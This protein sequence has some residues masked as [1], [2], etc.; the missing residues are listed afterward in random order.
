MTDDEK[1]D[2]W[3]AQAAQGY[4]EA[5][6]VP[7]EEMWAVIQGALP[8]Q[9]G[10]RTVARTA[11]RRPAAYALAA[12]AL[13]V[14]GIQIG[15]RMNAT[16]QPESAALARASATRE[17][18]T[19][20]EH[21]TVAHFERAEALLT[22]FKAGDRSAE[23]TVLTSWARDLLVDT[24]LMLDSPAANDPSRRALL[25]QLELALAQ[26]VLLNPKSTDAERNDVVNAFEKNQLM[27]RIRTAVPAGYSGT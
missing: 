10:K 1:F 27:T 2:M 17:P 23:D 24:R 26:I 12:T 14:V 13:L 15:S 19:T 6:H 9:V 7:K 16:E 5:P 18:S 11:W 25:E 8:T 22:S 21:A 4:H 3:I 20:L